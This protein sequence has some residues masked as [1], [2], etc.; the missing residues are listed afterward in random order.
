VADISS[1]RPTE[2]Y[3][4]RI[5]AE[6]LWRLEGFGVQAVE[7][8]MFGIGVIELVILFVGCV[9]IAVGVTI[10]I[11]SARGRCEDEL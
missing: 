1:G 7:T 2:C 5:E 8:T 3:S 10:A 11:L 9:V 4:L 6:V